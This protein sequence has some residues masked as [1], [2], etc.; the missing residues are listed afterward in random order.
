M[1]MNDQDKLKELNG[2][3]PVK[4][5]ILAAYFRSRSNVP[6][7]SIVGEELIADPKSTEEICADLMPMTMIDPNLV[8]AYML[9]KGYTFTTLDDGTIKWAIWRDQRYIG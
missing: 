8:A 6:G 7:T 3:G 2:Y 4:L 9:M 1:I 5:E